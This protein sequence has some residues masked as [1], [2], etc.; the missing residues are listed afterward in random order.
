MSMLLI[1]L[2]AYMKL[3]NGHKKRLFG[4]SFKI[5]LHYVILRNKMKYYTERWFK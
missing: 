5:M 2:F 4:S 1:Y 3:E